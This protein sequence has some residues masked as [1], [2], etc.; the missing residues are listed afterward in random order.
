MADDLAQTG[1][2]FMTKKRRNMKTRMLADWDKIMLSK[3]FII[4]TINEPFLK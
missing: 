2:T 1:V 4:E 3:R